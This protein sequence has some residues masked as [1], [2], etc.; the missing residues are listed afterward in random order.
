MPARV[1][2]CLSASNI[3]IVS[4]II[5]SYYVDMYRF[6][7]FY[8]VDMYRSYMMIPMCCRNA[9]H[10]YIFSLRMTS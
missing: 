9:A 2:S 4:L 7:I 8:I 3:L 10:G 5:K 1:I 6:M